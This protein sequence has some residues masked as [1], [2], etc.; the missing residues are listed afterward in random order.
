MSENYEPSEYAIGYLQDIKKD[1]Q[2]MKERCVSFEQ[3]HAG[4]CQRIH[5]DMNAFSLPLYPD[6][7]A[8]D[9]FRPGSLSERD[10]LMLGNY[11]RDREGMYLL[12]QCV[13][14]IQDDDI[15]QLAE[16]YYLERKTMPEIA[17]ELVRSKSYVSKKLDKAEKSD[18]PQVI[19]DYFEWKY[20]VPGG[21]DCF[22]AGQWETKY[23]HAQDARR[24]IIHLPDMSWM[25]KLKRLGF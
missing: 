11:L 24:G 7:P 18:M 10:R 20:S 19:D 22:W 2:K 21:K 16:L 6:Y 23:M 12:E 17:T 8:Q 4:F 15:R 5:L 3:D 1:Y 25:K 9:I 13:R 14:N